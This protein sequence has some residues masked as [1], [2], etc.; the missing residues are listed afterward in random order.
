MRQPS[1]LLAQRRQAG[2][3]QFQLR[4]RL[5]RL[6][7]RAQA[8]LVTR[9]RQ[10]PRGFQRGHRVERDPL[11]LLG[12]AQRHVAGG[13]LGQQTDAQR[14]ALLFLGLRLRIGGSSARRRPPNTSISQLAS[15]ANR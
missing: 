6:H 12:R 3:P 9:L 2:L 10:P 4:A 5:G 15:N 14:P 1:L 8:A 7:G 11:P 13:Q